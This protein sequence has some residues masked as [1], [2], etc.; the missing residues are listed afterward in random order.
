ME[1][2]QSQDCSSNQEW[3]GYCKE[4]G[5][6]KNYGNTGQQSED[7]K[8]LQGNSEKAEIEAVR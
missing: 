3:N 7:S 2:R 4:S 8:N 6:N 1:K 5:N